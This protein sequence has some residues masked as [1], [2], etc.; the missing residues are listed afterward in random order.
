MNEVM[1]INDVNLGELVKIYLTI[2][3]ERE[4][5]EAEWKAANDT[6]VADMKAIEAKML[7][8]CNQ[9]D[10]ASIR[11]VNGT[12]MR[13]LNERYTVSDGD[14]FRKFILQ[15]GAVDLF[16]A[17]IHQGNFKQF[18]AENASDGLPPGVNVMREFTVVVR[19]PSSN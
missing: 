6:L 18:I 9:N 2:R 11:T 19:K 16:E 8:T 13:R 12:V 3:N 14:S 4:R 5:I 1:E 15:N 10:A 7:D 17:R